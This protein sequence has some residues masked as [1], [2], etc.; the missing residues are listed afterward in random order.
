LMKV[1]VAELMKVAKEKEFKLL[2][3]KEQIHA[4][5]IAKIKANKPGEIPHKVQESKKVK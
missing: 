5:F 3:S 4:E 2:L 1:I